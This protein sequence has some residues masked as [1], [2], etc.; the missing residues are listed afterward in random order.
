MPCANPLYTPEEHLSIQSIMAWL[1]GILFAMNTVTLVSTNSALN[2][3]RCSR[4]NS[5]S[6]CVFQLSFIINWRYSKRFPAV[7]V[8]YMTVCSLV[9]TLGLSVQFYPGARE[10]ILCRKD[11]TSRRAEPT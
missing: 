1:V 11:G 3:K 8:L 7:A 9:A 6:H 2:L 10:S 5:F 4:P